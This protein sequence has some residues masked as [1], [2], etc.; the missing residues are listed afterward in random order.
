[1]HVVMT[2][3]AQHRVGIMLYL[4]AATVMMTDNILIYMFYHPFVMLLIAA[5]LLLEENAARRAG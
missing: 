4:Y 5:G 3:L 1:M 2:T